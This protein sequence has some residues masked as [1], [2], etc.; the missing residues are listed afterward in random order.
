MNDR[1]DLV[2]KFVH[3]ILSEKEILKPIIAHEI[4][5]SY[6]NIDE[7]FKRVEKIAD[8]LIEAGRISL[9]SQ[10]IEEEAHKVNVI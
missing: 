8:K 9:K 3:Q 7:E 1:V 10:I 6:R 4:G 5:K 2:K